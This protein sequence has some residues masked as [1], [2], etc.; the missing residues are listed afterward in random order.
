MNVDWVALQRLR[1]LGWDFIA[2]PAAWP[3][4]KRT[5]TAVAVL[6]KGA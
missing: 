2:V 3:F 1:H 5:C 6:H 4:A